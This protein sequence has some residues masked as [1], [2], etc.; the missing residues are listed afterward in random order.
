MDRY[1]VYHAFYFRMRWLRL[2][3]RVRWEDAVAPALEFVTLQGRMKFINP[4]YRLEGGHH[5]NNYI[6]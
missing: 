5:P 3:L 1:Y 6:N 2:C 4:I